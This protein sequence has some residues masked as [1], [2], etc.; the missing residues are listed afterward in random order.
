M[1]HELQARAKD[2]GD[3]EAQP[4]DENFIEALE[5]GL[6][7]CGGFGLGIERMTMLLSN[8]DNI[9]DIILF[10]TLKPL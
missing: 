9:D 7:P 1:I 10:P 6:P 4:I 8:R 2:N 3:E 5:Y